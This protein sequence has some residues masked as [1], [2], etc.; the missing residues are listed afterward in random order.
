MER[1]AAAGGSAVTQYFLTG[2]PVAA[3]STV[4]P[5]VKGSNLKDANRFQRPAMIFGFVVL[6][7]LVSILAIVR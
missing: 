2:G 1:C 4:I 7:I 6:F 5:V 3:L